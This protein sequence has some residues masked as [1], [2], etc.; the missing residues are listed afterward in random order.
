MLE[1]LCTSILR[2]NG[3]ITAVEGSRKGNGRYVMLQNK[4]VVVEFIKG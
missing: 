4:V 3:D 2:V 1:I